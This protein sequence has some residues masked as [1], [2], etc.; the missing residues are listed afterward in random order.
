M[1]VLVFLSI[2][3]F[4]LL[5]KSAAACGDPTFDPFFLNHVFCI[6]ISADSVFLYS[7]FL[8]EEDAALGRLKITS[9]GRIGRNLNRLGSFSGRKG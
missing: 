4:Y 9:L 2:L 5:H 1:A 7:Y 8:C 3:I 6:R